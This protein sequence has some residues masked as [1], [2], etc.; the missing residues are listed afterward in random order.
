MTD[1][2]Y[3]RY[4]RRQYI[5]HAFTYNIISKDKYSEGDEARIAYNNADKAG[6]KMLQLDFE[7]TP[8]DLTEEFDAAEKIESPDGLYAE[9]YVVGKNFS[10]TYIVTHETG[11]GIGPFFMQ[12]KK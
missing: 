4:I 2:Q 7:D 3:R 12:V 8:V 1:D 9:F 10:W 6:A 11:I 5:W